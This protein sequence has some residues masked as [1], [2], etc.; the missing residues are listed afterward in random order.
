MDPYLNARLEARYRVLC[1]QEKYQNWPP[2][3]SI[4]F[5]VLIDQRVQ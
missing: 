1:S 4:K 5:D 3:I 2:P